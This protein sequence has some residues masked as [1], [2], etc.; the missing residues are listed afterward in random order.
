MP[1]IKS[2]KKR[3]RQDKKRRALNFAVRRDLRDTIKSFVSLVNEG[4][5]ADAQKLYATVQKVIDTNAK[6]GIIHPNNAARKKAKYAKLLVAVAEP[7]KK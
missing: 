1:I 3:V 5:I 2:A 6:K 7:A 4:K